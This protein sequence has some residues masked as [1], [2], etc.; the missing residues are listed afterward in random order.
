MNTFHQMWGVKDP[1]EAQNI[2]NAQK[3][4]WW[5]GTWKFGG[6]GDFISWGGLIPS[7][8]K[9]LYGEAV[10]KKCKELP[11]FIIK[12]I[13]VRFTFDN[14]YFS[15]RYQGIPVGGYT[16]LIEKCLKVWT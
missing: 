3:K 13:P 14:N 11:A 7:I 5:Q 15:D 12:R 6:A 10:G 8:D 2:I 4:V 16:K 9:G 1:Q